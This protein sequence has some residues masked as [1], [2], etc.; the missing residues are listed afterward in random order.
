MAPRPLLVNAVTLLLDCSYLHEVRARSCID[1]K[2]ICKRV[3]FA[4]QLGTPR[5]GLLGQL[6]AGALQGLLPRFLH[7]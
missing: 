1:C 7:A 6:V 4:C 3:K 2:K 5:S